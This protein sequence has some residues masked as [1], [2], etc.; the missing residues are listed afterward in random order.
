MPERSRPPLPFREFLVK[1]HSRCN[2][3]CRYC[4][5]YESEDRGWRTQPAG[6]A[7]AT[8]GRLVLRIA[9]HARRHALRSVRVI[10]HGG[11]PLLAGGEFLARFVRGL[12]AALPAATR[13][14]VALQTNGTL[15]D[16][17]LLRLCHAEDI[18]IG[19]SLD[20]PP[21]VHDRYRRD[22]AGRGS[23][24]RVAAALE[25]LARPEHRPL[26]SGLL[27]TVDP[28]TDPLTTYDHLLSYDPPALTFILPLGN[29]TVPPPGRVPDPAR[30]PYADWLVQV[31]DRWYA[32]AGRAPRVTPFESVIDLLLGGASGSE[33]IGGGPS[34]LAV[35]DTDGSLT[36]SDHL[37]TTY[38][39][40]DRTGLSV[41]R[42]P[43]DALLRHPG[44]AA[45]QAGRAGL[46]AGCR[47]CPLVAVCGGGHYPHRY[48]AG[49]GGAG[50]DNPS[51][52]CPDL[53]R[54][55]GHVART[56]AAD[57]P[58]TATAKAVTRT[59]A[60]TEAKAMAGRT[61]GRRDAEH[62]R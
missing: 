43:F 16:E 60:A 26:W 51:V 8:A 13:A 30:T 3:A 35:I 27:T 55:I 46:C 33:V 11:E 20:G 15:L 38:D 9:E 37:K 25:L 58:A 1:V 49:S 54:F 4:Y 41:H 22:P 29:W 50:H 17:T 10:L 61:P 32:S 31:F 23:H 7:P 36:L 40:A 34:R 59:E 2:L 45:R 28:T 53:A 24:A 39:G 18:R 19:V 62:G 57:L 21:A 48:R 52:Y 42:D 14:E 5:V 56:V 44:V 12:R 6:M 47:A